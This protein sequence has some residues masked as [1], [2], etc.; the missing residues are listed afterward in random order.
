MRTSPST[1]CAVWWS[2]AGRCR[3]HCHVRM[4]ATVL[5]S[6]GRP[7]TVPLTHATAAARWSSVLVSI[8]PAGHAS[9][10]KHLRVVEN[11]P[12]HLR[13]RSNVCIVPAWQRVRVPR[14]SVRPPAVHS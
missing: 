3:L 2:Q 14:A 8:H 12:T 4:Q 11:R 10:V 1:C 6:H 7:P 9:A 13:L 5:R